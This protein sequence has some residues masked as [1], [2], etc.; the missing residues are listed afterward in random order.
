[1]A[2]TCSV[3]LGIQECVEQPLS[4]APSA[5]TI[6]VT[7]TKTVE[8]VHSIY[9]PAAMANKEAVNP[10]KSPNT[11][12]EIRSIYLPAVMAKKEAV[13]PSASPAT[14]RWH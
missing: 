5:I 2:P 13:N 8:E 4:I 1:M 11:V 14:M 9:L 7:T 12:E 10:V 3:S 6:N